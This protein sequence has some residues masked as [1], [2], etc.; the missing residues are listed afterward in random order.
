MDKLIKL[1]TSSKKRIDIMSELSKNPC[2]LADLSKALN[3]KPPNVITQLK[4]LEL[5]GIIESRGRIYGLSEFGRLIYEVLMGFRNC[6]E[7]IK[8]HDSFWKTHDTSSIPNHLL[9]RIGELG[10]CSIVKNP[11][12]YIYEIHEDVINNIISSNKIWG[13]YSVYHPKYSLIFSKLV[14]DGKKINLI[15]TEPLFKKLIREIPDN[16]KDMEIYITHENLKIS[17]IVSDKFLCLILYSKNGCY[18]A[19]KFLISFD[20]TALIWGTDLYDYYLK[21]SKKA[22]LNKYGIL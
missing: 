16:I 20:D 5:E 3:S 12:E 22:D 6:I 9:R 14:K 2:T 13:I 19:E 4:K 18:D 15:I 10:D 1:I 21:K 11:S 8:K 17:M 7:V